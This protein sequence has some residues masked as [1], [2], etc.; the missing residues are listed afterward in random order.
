MMVI[1]TY[2]ILAKFRK[3]HRHQVHAKYVE[4]RAPFLLN[5]IAVHKLLWL[6]IG[7][8]LIMTNAA[9]EDPANTAGEI[10]VTNLT[11]QVG[12][13]RREREPRFSRKSKAFVTNFAR[14]ER[15]ESRGIV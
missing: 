12:A 1:N 15:R 6:K 7:W 3:K 14:S 11:Q 4:W 9:D 2:C 10:R 13:E 5:K 8:L